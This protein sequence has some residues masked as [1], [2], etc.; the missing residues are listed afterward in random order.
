[1]RRYSFPRRRRR[2][3]AAIALVAAAVL[4]G[5]AG[6]GLLGGSEPARGPGGRDPVVVAEM[7]LMDVAPLHLGLDRGFFA[8][9]GVT[10]TTATAASG[11]GAIAKLVSDEVAIAYASDVAAVLAAAG[12]AGDFAI[13]AEASS[14]PPK[15]LELVVPKN[16]PIKSVNDLPGKRIAINAKH[17]LSDTLVM[18][19]LTARGV[20]VG[21]DD[22]QWAEMPFPSMAGAL[23]RGDVDAAS[24]VEPFVTEAAKDGA[25]E[26]LDLASGDTKDFP[27]SCYLA[28]KSWVRS[29]PAEV[30]AFRAGLRRAVDLARNDP[31]TVRA[32]VAG[33]AKIKP[34]DAQLVKLPDFRADIAPVALQRVPDLLKSYGVIDKRFDITT[35]ILNP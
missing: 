7:P 31:G 30:A 25:E 33:Y 19:A 22:I 4:A 8:D 20:K 18:A 26:V 34:D 15:T 16:S 24:T 11:Q 28:K 27:V 23:R 21:Y 29:H 35:L 10:V 13:I 3:S 9:A 17:G 1:M 5:T 2:G 14:A 32:V 6:C 12:K